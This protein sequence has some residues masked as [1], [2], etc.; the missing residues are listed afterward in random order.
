M[1]ALWRAAGLLFCGW[2]NPMAHAAPPV[3]PDSAFI[4]P[5]PCRVDP[6]GD[7][8]P[9]Q[10]E[11][12]LDRACGQDR[13]QMRVDGP[14]V[15][16]QAV[17]MATP[18]LEV[19]QLLSRNDGWLTHSLRLGWSAALDDKAGRLQTDHALLAAGTMLRLSEDWALDMNV[20]RDVGAKLPTRTTVTG[21]W[22]GDY[23]SPDWRRKTAREAEAI[24]RAL[25][26]DGAFWA[27]PNQG[28]NAGLSVPT[29]NWPAW[30]RLRLPLAQDATAA[31][32][33]VFEALLLEPPQPAARIESRTTRRIAGA[34]RTK[35]TLTR[36]YFA[37]CT[38]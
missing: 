38:S 4:V 25:E 1:K 27:P 7:A 11:L 21:L 2:V 17:A 10:R 9:E 18:K 12:Q 36:R 22:F 37:S 35:A 32:D 28:G 34:R 6:Y 19:D 20:G 16:P 13:L 33:V 29:V 24:F 5:Q 26:L 14:R 8:N 30:T 3:L 15:Q 23:A 31:V